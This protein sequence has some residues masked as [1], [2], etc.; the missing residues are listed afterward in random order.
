MEQHLLVGFWRW[1]K[2]I[3]RKSKSYL[4]NPGIYEVTLYTSDPNSCNLIDSISK[5]VEIR[6]HQSQQLDSLFI[7]KGETVQLDFSTQQISLI[8]DSIIYLNDPNTISPIA[9][10]EDSI[11]YYLIGNLG[12]CYDT[13]SQHIAVF[14]VPLEVSANQEIC[15]DPIWLFAESNDE[16]SLKWSE[17]ATFSAPQND[18]LLAFYPGTYFVKAEQLGCQTSGATEVRLSQIVVQ[19]IKLKYLMHLV[20]ME[21]GKMTH[22][23]LKTIPIS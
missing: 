12:D 11:H 3:C 15:G 1:T 21:M 9:Q 8:L 18:S 14:E 7:C 13:L 2:F 16:A 5:Y 23:S 19:K 22:S 4:Y 17:S 10:P 20:Q 6:T